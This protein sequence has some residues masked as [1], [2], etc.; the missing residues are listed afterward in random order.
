MSRCSIAGGMLL[1]GLAISASD[2][3]AQSGAQ[4]VW[5][6]D[7]LSHIGG[8]TPKVEGQPVLVDSPIGKAV[9]FNGKDTGLFFG[10]RPLVG[11]ATF[12]IEGIFRPEG[13]DFE[14]RWMHVVE[15]DPATGLDAA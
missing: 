3:W 10:S 9:Q 1:C 5:K 2:S 4:V 7:N 13:G 6:F 14:Q 15:T 8:L 11:A 12:T